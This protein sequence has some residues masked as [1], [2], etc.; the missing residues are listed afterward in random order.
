MIK[1]GLLVSAV[2][3][4]LVGCAG[5]AGDK[6]VLTIRLQGGQQNA[7]SIAQASLVGRGDITD[8]TYLIGGVPVGVS[9]PVQLYTF[10]YSG[11][12]ARLSA[13]PAYSMNNTVQTI[14]TVS[15]WRLLREVPVAL[16]ALLSEPHALLVRTSPAD[17]N[18]DI[19]CGDIRK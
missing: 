19:F 10:I 7:A 15:G 11:S 3:G 16:R 8:I 17:G 18:T 1:T 2:A 14:P 5:A 9:R 12:C 6:E 13:K 4:L